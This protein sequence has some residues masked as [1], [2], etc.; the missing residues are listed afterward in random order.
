MAIGTG[1]NGKVKRYTGG[2]GAG[3]GNY[4]G[5]ADPY[6][7]Q[8]R[9]V[10]S[11]ALRNAAPT[12]NKLVYDQNTGRV[13][14]KT[15][16][17]NDP[18]IKNANKVRGDLYNAYNQQ[19]QGLV[20]QRNFA[21]QNTNN[22]YNGLAR[23]IY[24]AYMNSARQR[25]QLASNLGM[26]GGAVENLMVGNENN[27]NTNYAQSEGLRAKALAENQNTFDTNVNNAQVDYNKS[28][29][30]LYRDARDSSLAAKETEK[31]RRLDVYQNTVARFDTE[32]KCKNE[33]KKLKKS[34]DANK[35]LKIRM[36]QAQLAAV[37]ALKNG[38]QV[39]SA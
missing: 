6:Y 16:K 10:A 2:S 31:A 24:N 35:A 19:Y 13:V 3:G 25:Q 18:Y 8:T 33:I 5:V 1:I 22:T 34:N 30:D 38:K 21:N 15:P 12:G 39:V 9:Q 14:E 20:N 17:T 11:T 36:V 26:T 23:N 27:Y 7:K 28:I 37:R 32:K 29:A 4:R